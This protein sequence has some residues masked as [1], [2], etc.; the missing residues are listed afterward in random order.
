MKLP[1]WSCR[2]IAQV[3]YQW[4]ISFTRSS[5]GCLRFAFERDSFDRYS[6]EFL[7]SLPIEARYF[8]E[9]HYLLDPPFRAS[10][11]SR[12]LLSF[13]GLSDAFTTERSGQPHT[14]RAASGQPFDGLCL[15]CIE[16]SVFMVWSH[17]ILSL[18]YLTNN[19]WTLTWAISDWTPIIGVSTALN[20]E[21]FNKEKTSEMRAIVCRWFTNSNGSPD[22]V[23]E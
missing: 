9:S 21:T 4:R 6:N 2:E 11:S 7:V 13:R 22:W 16:A 15:G 18:R 1:L 19:V 17:S 23:T 8:L 10:L 5:L 14:G 12:V 20:I 3:P